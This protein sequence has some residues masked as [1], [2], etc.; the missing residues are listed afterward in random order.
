MSPEEVE[1]LSTFE[2][3]RYAD[4]LYQDSEREADREKA[5]YKALGPMAALFNLKK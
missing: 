4:L 1:Q 3:T 2:V 5:L